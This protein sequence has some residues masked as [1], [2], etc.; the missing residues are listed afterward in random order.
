MYIYPALRSFGLSNCFFKYSFYTKLRLEFSVRDYV[1]V[2]KTVLIDTL[3]G[4]V[5]I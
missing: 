5:F 3:S 1:R 4:L 2:K